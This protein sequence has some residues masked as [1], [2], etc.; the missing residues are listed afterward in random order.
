[1]Q[2]VELELSY[3]PLSWLKTWGNI[4]YNDT[5]DTVNDRE[6][7]YTVNYIA[8]LGFNFILSQKSNAAIYTHFSG[9]MKRPAS[10]VLQNDDINAWSKT[11]IVLN[12][13][14]MSSLQISLI[15]KNIFDD[16]RPAYPSAIPHSTLVIEDPATEGR[17][18]IAGLR[19]EF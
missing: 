11:N 10:F 8:N 15:A 13:D 16:K 9:P 17:Q 4:G 2:G 3:L 7:D 5:K 18:V 19:Y 12:H 6:Y 1:M 14:I